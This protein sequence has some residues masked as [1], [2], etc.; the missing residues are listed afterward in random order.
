M[1]SIRTFE[2]IW[3]QTAI[4]DGQTSDQSEKHNVLEIIV[5]NLSQQKRFFVSVTLK[6]SMAHYRLKTFDYFRHFRLQNGTLTAQTSI[7]TMDVA[8][9]TLASKVKMSFLAPLYELQ[10]EL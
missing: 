4:V 9:E 1:Y 6:S 5:Y 10:V 8:M 7:G 2:F 3:K